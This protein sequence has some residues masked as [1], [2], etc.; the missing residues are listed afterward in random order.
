MEFSFVPHKN[1][2]A[3]S[4]GMK[5]ILPLPPSVS[6]ADGLD[7]ETYNAGISG[8]VIEAAM[9][10]A[11]SGDLTALM[12]ATGDRYITA[13]GNVDFGKLKNE[14]TSKMGTQT[15]KNAS[16]L[17]AHP[18]TR[19]IFKAPNLR[20]MQFDFKLVALQGSDSL[21][22]KEIIKEFRKNAYPEKD[23]GEEDPNLF[24]RLPNLCKIKM[25]LGGMI[26]PPRFKDMYITNVNV[27]YGGQV[28][29]EYD[30]NH[31]F[32][33]TNLSIGLTESETLTS[34]RVVEGY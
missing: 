16:G 11:Q 9:K 18:D 31:W 25:Y 24:Y 8:Q 28:L 3:G 5:V 2:S 33:E 15:M 26:I 21:L 12:K 19:S 14:L 27:T 22:I 13:D 30:A 6:L 23:G 34:Q 29:S 10:Q 1:N 7:Y 4:G 20:T 17:R 32:S